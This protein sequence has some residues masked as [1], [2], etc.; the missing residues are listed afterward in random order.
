MYPV[1]LWLHHFHLLLLQSQAS[2]SSMSFASLISYTHM[3]TSSFTTW[4]G[5]YFQLG[6]LLCLSVLI[7]PVSLSLSLSFAFPRPT[8]QFT[9]PRCILHLNTTEK[10]CSNYVFDNAGV[11]SMER[12]TQVRWSKISNCT[13]NLTFWHPFLLAHFKSPYSTAW[14]L[15]PIIRSF[16]WQQ[17]CYF[18]LPTGLW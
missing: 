6:L 7:L 11:K 15:S 14:I 10:N 5:F 3:V 8:C 18:S 9:W 16:D 2:S 13:Q 17:P 1:S 12:I 4:F